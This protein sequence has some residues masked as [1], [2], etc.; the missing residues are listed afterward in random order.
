VVAALGSGQ[1]LDSLVSSKGLLNLAGRWI[2]ASVLGDSLSAQRFLTAL[3]VALGVV[4]A[5]SIV[6]VTV[7]PPTP[8]ASPFD[9]VIRNFF[10]N[11]RRAH[12]FFSIY[13]T[14]AA[15]CLRS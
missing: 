9:G 1:P 4:A 7:C 2:V 3:A 13:M 14:L 12:G 10:R 6:Q 15:S 11:C 8:P 5:V